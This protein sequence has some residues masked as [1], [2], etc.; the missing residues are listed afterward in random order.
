[1]TDAIVT[2]ATTFAI[3]LLMIAAAIWVLHKFEKKH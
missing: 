1:M 3:A 2:V